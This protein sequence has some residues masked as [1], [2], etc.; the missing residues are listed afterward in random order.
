MTIDRPAILLTTDLS[1]EAA[2]AYAP[3]VDLARRLGG[4][5]LFVHI[6][7]VTAIAPHG[8]PL[9]PVQIPPDTTR[10]ITVARDQLE[11]EA[12]KLGADVP[13]ELVCEAAASAVDHIVRLAKERHAQLI[14]I[15]THGRRGLRRLMLGS[16][17]E[18]IVRH[19]TVPVL[20]FPPE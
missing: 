10:A 5:I 13:V 9:A 20:T 15:S 4:R 17:A 18:A 2:R 12:K 3:T 8:A 19:A 14:A 6:V 11:V 7:E 16:V 1:T